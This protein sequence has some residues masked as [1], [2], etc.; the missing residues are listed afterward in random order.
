MDSLELLYNHYKETMQLMQGAKVER[1]KYFLILCLLIALLFLLGIEPT[2]TASFIEAWLASVTGGSFSFGFNII[3][4]AVWLVLLFYTLKYYQRNIY[5]ERQY[6]YLDKLE[7]NIS[8]LTNVIFNR[9]GEEYSENYPC[10]LTMIDFFYK[11][12]FP[13]LYFAIVFYKIYLEVIIGHT[14]INCILAIPILVLTL[15]YFLFI[16]NL[17]NGSYH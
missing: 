12:F 10:V 2:G 17:F 6:A 14:F 3:Q 11:K 16:N 9:E 1:D 15:A 4:S 13:I 7:R 5:V 8:R